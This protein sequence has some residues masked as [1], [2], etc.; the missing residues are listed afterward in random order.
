MKCFEKGVG[1]GV[2]TYPN[3]GTR[4][5]QENVVHTA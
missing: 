3:E 5:P 1:G 2:P 4:K